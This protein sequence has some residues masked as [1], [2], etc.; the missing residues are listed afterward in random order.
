MFSH[1]LTCPNNCLSLPTALHRPLYY[2]A[3]RLLT[4]GA[5]CFPLS[6]RFDRG[7]VSERLP[8]RR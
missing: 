7:G 6:R 3:Y 4:D 2:L 1:V 5:R 8:P